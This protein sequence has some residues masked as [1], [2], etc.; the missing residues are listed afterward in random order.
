[1]FI[2][3][4]ALILIALAVVF[5]VRS[6]YVQS[7]HHQAMAVRNYRQWGLMRHEFECLSNGVMVLIGRLY[8]HPE[9]IKAIENEVGEYTIL[10]SLEMWK[11]AYDEND[12]VTTYRKVREIIYQHWSQYDYADVEQDMSY[13]GKYRSE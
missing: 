4:W 8:D 6:L 11:G 12:Y 10:S 13:Y 5:T 9:L 3:M 7:K 2:P 1:M